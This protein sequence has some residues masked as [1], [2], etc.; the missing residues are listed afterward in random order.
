MRDK[1]ASRDA[2]LARSSAAGLPAINV[3]LPVR[4]SPALVAS[5]IAHPSEF[6]RF[7][8]TLDS[9]KI[10]AK[11]E[12]SIVYDW[13]F[14]LALFHLRG[15]NTLTVYEAPKSRPD[16]GHRITIDSEEGDLGRGRLCT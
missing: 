4:A 12:N 11:H 3:A 8:P 15:R 13:A 2:A 14:D 9:V 16:A 5:T 10:V 1:I 7:M 6:P